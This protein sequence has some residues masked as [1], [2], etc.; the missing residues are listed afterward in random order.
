MERS[1]N[2]LEDKVERVTEIK[3]KGGDVVRWWVIVKK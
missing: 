1:V 3:L 2:G